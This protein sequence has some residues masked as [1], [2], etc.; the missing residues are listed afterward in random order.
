[1]IHPSR[2][3]SHASLASLAVLVTGAAFLFACT[4]E[5]AAGTKKR[6][7]PMEPG[8]EFYD[9][10]IPSV[11]EGLA[12]TLNEDSGAFGA[13]SRPSSGPKD[14][15]PIVDAGPRDSGPV[16][17]KVYCDGALKTGDL[18]VAELLISSRAGSGDDGEW[19]E[20]RS[21]RTCWLKLKG[22]TISSPRGTA[23]SNS[24][25]IAEDYE[26][27]PRGSFVVA[28]SLDPLKNHGLAG[29]VFAWE[30]ADVLKND[31]DTIKLELGAAV[32]DTLTYPAF[33]NLVAGRTL[34]FPDDCAWGVR[35][36]WQ[37]WSLTFDEWKPGFKG[38]PNA[39]NDDVACY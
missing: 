9:D 5:Q 15:G 4:A 36:D 33:S 28:D 17:P 1:M 8:D 34:A 6:R 39:T 11:E 23:T 21:T 25:Q 29:K 22:L 27:E 19:I 2:F 14:G 7:T 37:R 16:G 30:A 38:T 12:P 32:V 13:S 10:D 24:V 18:A 31:G 3:R 35:A 20:I 26:L